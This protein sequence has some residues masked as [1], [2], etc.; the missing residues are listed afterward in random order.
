MQQRSHEPHQE[1]RHIF[2]KKKR[3]GAS[4]QSLKENE[5][6]DGLIMSCFVVT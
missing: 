4:G 6:S 2:L 1:L 3:L 5:F